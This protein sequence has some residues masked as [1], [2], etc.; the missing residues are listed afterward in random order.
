MKSIANLFSAFANLAA[1]LNALAGVVDVATGQIRQR[2]EHEAMTP[3][4]IEHQPA[5]DAPK[6]RKAK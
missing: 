2:L 4:V 6:G 5:E 1:S 3:A